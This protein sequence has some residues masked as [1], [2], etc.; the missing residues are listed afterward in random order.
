MADSPSHDAPSITGAPLRPLD[1]AWP[2]AERIGWWILDAV[3]LI[4]TLVPIVATAGAEFE[5]LVHIPLLCAWLLLAALL[6]WATLALPRAAYRRAR[7][8]LGDLGLEYRRGIWW[9]KT[10]IVPRSRVQHTDVAQGPLLRRFGLGKLVIHTAGTR[11]ATV[12]IP[13]L[14]F[15]EAERIRDQLLAEG[16][17]GPPAAPAPGDESPA[18]HDRPTDADPQPEPPAAHGSSELPFSD[19]PDAPAPHPPRGD[20]RD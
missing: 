15:A 1:P 10:T 12:E 18:A 9:R 8:A 2:K 17:E 14:A 13:G 7:I 6:L 19:D 20:A 3:V 11:N 4:P 5:P 16:G